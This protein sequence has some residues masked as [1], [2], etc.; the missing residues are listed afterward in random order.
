MHPIITLRKNEERRIIAGHLWAFSNEIQ[1]ISGEPAAG[2]IAELRTHAGKFIGLGF[3]NPR[4][5]IAIIKYYFNAGRK[6][7]I[8]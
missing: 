2:D 1:E 4:S 6:Q 8:I 5:L 7:R 3:Y